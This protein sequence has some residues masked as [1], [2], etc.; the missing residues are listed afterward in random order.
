M[1]NRADTSYTIGFQFQACSAF[2]RESES[3]LGVKVVVLRSGR[4]DFR[5]RQA[6]RNDSARCEA[7]YHQQQKVVLS[8]PYRI[9]VFKK[10]LQ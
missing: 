2:P 5:P 4:P 9:V 1:G 6:N 3:M 10:Q 8:S 7:T